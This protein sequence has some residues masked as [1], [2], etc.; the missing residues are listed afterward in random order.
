MIE[1]ILIQR[2]QMNF[3]VRDIN[4]YDIIIYNG[5]WHPLL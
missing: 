2:S 3:M 4:S 1:L 5:K